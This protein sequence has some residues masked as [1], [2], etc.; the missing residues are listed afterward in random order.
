MRSPNNATRAINPI[1]EPVPMSENYYEN[2][3]WKDWSCTIMAFDYGTQD[4]LYIQKYDKHRYFI[5]TV[6]LP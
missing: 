5:H 1:A 4:M 2:V 3:E 6:L